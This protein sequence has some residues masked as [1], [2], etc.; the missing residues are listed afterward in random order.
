[1]HETR[2]MARA[3][4]LGPALVALLLAVSSGS[5]GS[6]SVDYGAISHSGLRDLGPA[7]TGLKLQL[8]LGLVAD[9]QASRT[10]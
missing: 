6:T 9:Q 4:A 7:S 10:R 5:A 1:M 2:S 3:L 8:E